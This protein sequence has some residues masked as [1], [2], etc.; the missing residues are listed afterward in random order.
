MKSCFK[1][2]ISG[3]LKATLQYRLALGTVYS[4]GYML[5]PMPVNMQW[6]TLQSFQSPLPSKQFQVWFLAE[7]RRTLRPLLP[8]SCVS[9]IQI[10]KSHMRLLLCDRVTDWKEKFW[11]DPHLSKKVNKKDSETEIEVWGEKGKEKGQ[12][13]DKV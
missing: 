11:S 13:G 12:E 5:K 4:F 1:L 2:Q 3:H 10:N 9:G 6:T 8:K 7:E